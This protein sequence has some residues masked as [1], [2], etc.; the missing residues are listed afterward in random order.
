MG[1]TYDCHYK[2]C[3]VIEF[4]CAE[5]ET[6]VNIHKRLCAVYGDAA[7]DR[8]TVGRWVK[9][10]Q[11]SG[12]AE[13]ELHDQPRSGRPVTSTAPDMLNRADAI[14]RADRRITT[15]QLALQLS[16]SIGSACAMI[17]TLGYAKSYSRWIPRMLTIDHK[18]QRKAISSELLQRFETDGEAFLS[19]IITGDESWVHHFAPETKRQSLEWHH[20][21]SPHKK[22]FKATP[23]A[24]KVMV[25][26]FWDCDGVILVDVM[27]R[28]STIN[29]EAYV[30]TLNKLRNRFRRV[31][32]D[33]NPAEILLQHDNA[34]PHTSLRT[35][36]HIAKLGWTS[37]PH[38]PYSPDLAPSDFHLFGPLKDSLRGTHFEDDESVIDAVKTWLRVQ[39]K[40][41]YR[42][43]IHALTQRWRKAVERDGD[44]VEK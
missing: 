11:T 20:P 30:K 35:R 24:G 16:V 37:L 33:K 38:P 4:L 34:R 13:T 29:S 32:S 9:R 23:S 2:Q 18:I 39:D 3:A 22:K 40:S 42:Q 8:S 36:E 1:S 25:T 44:Y 21:H 31:R 6:V 26:V 17:E 14:I 27:P 10:V 41:F 7:V 15:R 19:R 5:K 28:G 12:N 43:G